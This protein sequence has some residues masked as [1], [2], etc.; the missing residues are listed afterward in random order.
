IPD[1]D[2]ITVNASIRRHPVHRKK[3]TVTDQGRRSETRFAKISTGLNSAFVAAWPRT[4]RTHQIRVHLLYSGFPI[5]GDRVYAPGYHKRFTNIAV[6]KK[7]ADFDGV[8]LH[9]YRLK[10]AHPRTKERMVFT[11]D[12]PADFKNIMQMLSFPDA[13]DYFRETMDLS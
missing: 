12:I 10:I 7:L 5:I 13:D 3:M 4:G 11:S 8:C 1:W 2:E 9:A 6:Q